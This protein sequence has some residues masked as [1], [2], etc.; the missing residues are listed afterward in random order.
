MGEP[1]R[2]TDDSLEERSLNKGASA[3]A[4]AIVE[5]ARARS[6]GR[7]GVD[8]HADIVTASVLAVLNA[9]LRLG[10]TAEDRPEKPSIAA[11]RA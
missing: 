9:V 5:A 1:R 2:G 11:P 10:V 7:F 4:M 8:M 6:G 3:S